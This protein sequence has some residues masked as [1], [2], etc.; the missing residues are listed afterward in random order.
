MPCPDCNQGDDCA[1]LWTVDTPQARRCERD[2]VATIPLGSHACDVVVSPDGDHIY[3]TTEKSVKVID[4]AHRVVANIPVDLD[5]KRTMVSPDGSR[6]YVTGYNGSI[7]IINAVDYTVRT[8]V[9]DASTAEVVSPDDNYVYLAHNQGRNCWVSVMSDDGST[10]TVVPVD[11]YASALTLS[12]DGGRLYVASS[13]PR[14]SHQRHHGS[15]SVIDTATFTLIDVI[16]MQFSP[17]AII[18]SPD[19]SR[20]YASHYNKNAISAIELVSN[21]HTLIG[22]DDAPLDIAVSPD[23]DQLYATNLHSLA[24]IDTATNVAESVPIGDL[25]RRLHISGDGKQAYITDFGHHCV[26]VLDTVSKAVIT[27]VDLGRDPEAL[28]LGADEQFLYVADRLAPTLRVIS[29]ASS[30]RSRNRAG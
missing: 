24:L 17:D 23:G 10:V 22:L 21:S 16:A 25:P 8:V 18:V 13:K 4:R 7:S 19:G 1:H 20:V 26:W 27:T 5:P 11:S 29:L 30:E 15:I 28:A 2:V 12:P 6:L 14:S 9:R 3:A